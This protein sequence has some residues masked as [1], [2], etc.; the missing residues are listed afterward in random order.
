MAGDLTLTC[1]DV[2]KAAQRRL[3]NK[4]EQQDL[5]RTY[6][7]RA[8]TYVQEAFKLGTRHATWCEQQRTPAA[9]HAFL[10]GLAPGLLRE[11]APPRQGMRKHLCNAAQRGEGYLR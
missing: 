8:R 9:P 1:G 3:R 2:K 6:V 5:A 4:V 7:Q 10:R 11:E